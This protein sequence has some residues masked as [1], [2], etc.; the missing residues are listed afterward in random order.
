[1][2][3]PGSRR[4]TRPRRTA[5]D[6]ARTASAW[7]TTR[8]AQ[9]LFHLEELLGFGLEH[10]RDRDA[11]PLAEHQGHLLLVDDVVRARARVADDLR[12]RVVRR[13]ELAP[14]VGEQHVLDLAELRELLLFSG[15]GELLLEAVHVGAERRLRRDG[16][17]ARL[18]AARASR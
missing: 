16:A 3:F 10:L 7:P 13:F 12:D 1:M 18:D 8:A 5:R 6:T 11:G 2:G 4:P 14:R 15:F 17:A 9:P